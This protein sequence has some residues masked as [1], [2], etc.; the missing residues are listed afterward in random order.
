MIDSMARKPAR[1]AERL[2]IFYDKGHWELLVS[3]RSAAIEL[4]ETFD[5]SNISVIT[6]GSVARGDVTISSDI[7]IF[8]DDPPSS[9]AIETALER[10]GFKPK[11][12]YLVQATPYY[13]VKGYIEVNE[14]QTISFPLMK[15]RQVEREFYRFGGEISL[16]MLK[17]DKRVLGVD[18]RLMLIEPTETGHVESSIVGQEEAAARV[19]DVSPNTVL[20]RVNALLRR[21]KIGRTGVF[22]DRELSSDETF[23]GVLK[24]L[25]ETRPEVRR[26]LKSHDQ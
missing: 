9:F 16:R 14:L 24:R 26:R 21:D 4:M 12:R 18:K 23:E 6:H 13:A 15:M 19:L 22:L 1:R 11:R 3:L 25:V 10:S 17:A 5:G 20:D 2:E 7:D 8:A